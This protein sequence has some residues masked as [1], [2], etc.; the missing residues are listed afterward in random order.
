MPFAKQRSAR[1]QY[2]L[3]VWVEMSRACEAR[4]PAPE[5]LLFSFKS[6]RDSEFSQVPGVFGF[7]WFSFWSPL[8]IPNCRQVCQEYCLFAHFLMSLRLL[9]PLAVDLLFPFFLFPFS[10]FHSSCCIWMRSWCWFC[11]CFASDSTKAALVPAMAICC[12]FLCNLRVSLADSSAIV[13]L[14]A[15]WRLDDLWFWEQRGAKGFLDEQTYAIWCDLSDANYDP[16]GRGHFLYLLHVLHLQLF[17]PTDTHLRLGKGIQ[18]ALFEV[19]PGVD[20]DTLHWKAGWYGWIQL[21]ML[22]TKV[23]GSFVFMIPHDV[24]W[25]PR[26]GEE[27]AMFGYVWICLATISISAQLFPF[28]NPWHVFYGF[29]VAD[30]G[31]HRSNISK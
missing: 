10:E 29:F 18:D 26:N 15:H 11:L 6:R 14:S 13:A 25:K 21:V 28:C 17:L 12:L 30:V 9:F 4:A 19:P 5:E 7:R 20:L 27:V 23:S 22:L 1:P 2:G 8:K 24:S 31:W 16:G 3:T